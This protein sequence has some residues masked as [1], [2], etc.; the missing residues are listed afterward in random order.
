MQCAGGA[1]LIKTNGK[2]RLRS[3]MVVQMSETSE[4][5]V[6]RAGGPVD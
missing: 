3:F 1:L 4:V 2:C 6:K 5:F